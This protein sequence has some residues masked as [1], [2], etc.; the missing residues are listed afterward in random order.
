[1]T[2]QTHFLINNKQLGL[3]VGEFLSLTVELLRYTELGLKGQFMNTFLVQIY[4]KVIESLHIVTFLVNGCHSNQ[5]YL[6]KRLLD[7]LLKINY[8]S[9]QCASDFELFKSVVPQRSLPRP[10]NAT[11]HLIIVT[12]SQSAHSHSASKSDQVSLTSVEPEFLSP[13]SIMESPSSAQVTQ[14]PTIS[15]TSTTSIQSQPS[16]S[17]APYADGDSQKKIIH[18][19]LLSLLGNPTFVE[20][21]RFWL[22]KFARVAGVEDSIGEDKPLIEDGLKCTIARKA[23]LLLLEHVA[24]TVVKES[25]PRLSPQC[26]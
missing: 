10:V 8:F 22:A 6:L 16:P 17:L 1:M 14:L 9:L 19:S 2:P 20:C 25:K 21:C 26:E 15:R 18:K 5:F 3:N 13:S 12:Q 23:C 7:V 4:F 11:P 24:A